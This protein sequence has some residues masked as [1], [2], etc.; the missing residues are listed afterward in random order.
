MI[1]SKKD[2]QEIAVS[3]QCKAI[4]IKM[5]MDALM[6]TCD[7]LAHIIKDHPEE[8]GWL[9]TNSEN[10]FDACQALLDSADEAYSEA[11]ELVKIYGIEDI[12]KS[13]GHSY[14]TWGCNSV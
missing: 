6:N 1:L 5:R 4:D 12:E 10:I 7:Q 9:A 8:E 14:D 13:E 3:I 2:S 11:L